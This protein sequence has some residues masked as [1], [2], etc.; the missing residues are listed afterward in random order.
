[1]F[2][3]KE[4]DYRKEDFDHIQMVVIEHLSGSEQIPPCTA[5]QPTAP[6]CSNRGESS[7]RKEPEG[8]PAQEFV[9]NENQHGSPRIPQRNGNGALE[10]DWFP[11]SE[12]PD[13]DVHVTL[14]YTL[15]PPTAKDCR[16]AKNINFKEFTSTWLS[17]SAKG[18]DLRKH[19]DFETLIK[20]DF[21]EP[22]CITDFSSQLDLD[23]LPGITH[24]ET[25]NYFAETGLK[26]VL[27]KLGGESQPVDVVG[28]RI[29]HA[30]K[31]NMTSWVLTNVAALYWR[32]EGDAKRAIQCLRLS[33]TTAPTEV[34]DTSLISI[35]NVL[36][37]AGYINDAIVAT[38][39]ALHISNQLVVSHF[40]MANLYAAKEQWDKAKM[41]YESTLGLQTSFG[42]AKQRLKAIMCKM[43]KS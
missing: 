14:Q 43:L 27:Q 30:L 7:P 38:D 8:P 42:P 33:L 24:S 6:P 41:Y 16:A 37:R 17:V 19:I 34:K 36:H 28:T 35:A 40:T 20:R 3:L 39:L 9:D 29:A 4:F 11:D 18:I 23:S 12:L 1:M 2:Q 10:D 22:Y 21:E 31:K 26:E 13:T 32:V 15:R 5:H 25:L